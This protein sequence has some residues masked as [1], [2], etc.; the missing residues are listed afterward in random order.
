[1]SGQLVGANPPGLRLQPVPDTSHVPA[2]GRAA[3]H[4]PTAA[5]TPG[6]THS[7]GPPGV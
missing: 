7:Q 2:A 5:P 3:E 6:R 1:M 4:D